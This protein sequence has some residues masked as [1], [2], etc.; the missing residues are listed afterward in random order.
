MT[1]TNFVAAQDA[2]QKILEIA[3]IQIGGSP[4]DFEIANEKFF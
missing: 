4:S 2:L 1:R 3:A